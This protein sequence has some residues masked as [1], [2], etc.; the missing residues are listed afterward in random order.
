MGLAGVV[1]GCGGLWAAVGQHA[2]MAGP[3]GGADPSGS[4]LVG[5]TEPKPRGVGPS[6]RAPVTDLLL[7]GTG[8]LL[9]RHHTLKGVT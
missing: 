4:F 2:I 9:W 1:Q 8:A 5:G 6:Q 7:V 3:W